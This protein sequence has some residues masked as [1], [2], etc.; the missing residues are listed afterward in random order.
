MG[1]RPC[2][3]A[4]PLIKWDGPPGRGCWQ[5]PVNQSIQFPWG[6]FS[7]P[8][9]LCPEHSGPQASNKPFKRAERL[10]KRASFLLFYLKLPPRIHGP[11]LGR[12]C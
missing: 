1:G 8:C 5:T 6:H 7:S 11:A 10:S 2:S 4:E 12:V 9:S 3:Q